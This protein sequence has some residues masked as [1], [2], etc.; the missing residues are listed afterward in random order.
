M[1]KSS[2]PDYLK[3]GL[4]AVGA[5]IAWPYISQMLSGVSTVIPASTSTTVAPA[6]YSQAA[7]QACLGSGG[8]WDPNAN[9]CTCPPQAPNFNGST[10][11]PTGPIGVSG[12]RLR[13]NYR[14]A[15]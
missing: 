13:R 10:C 2:Q 7:I 1:A 15:A 11:S 8:D 12:Y 6:A 3:W 14:R 4:L 9:A 5:Y